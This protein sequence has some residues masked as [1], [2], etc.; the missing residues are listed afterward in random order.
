ME[1][2]ERGHRELIVWQQAVDLS[3]QIILLSEAF[4]Q[5]HGFVL[6]DQMQRSG[7]SIPNNIAEGSGR[8]TKKDYV[9]FLR[10]ARGS[11]RELDT[12][13]EIA[14]RI[15]ALPISE[16]EKLFAACSSIGRLLTRLIQS[17]TNL[18]P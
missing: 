10:I 4:A 16:A 11:L 5:R 18:K 1:K 8:G 6:R 14:V 15:G 17:L 9:A 7:M 3:V 2:F 12:Q 13:I